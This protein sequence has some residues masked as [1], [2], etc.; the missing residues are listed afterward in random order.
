[1]GYLDA[2]LN[3]F[4]DFYDVVKTKKETTPISRPVFQ[5]GFNEMIILEAAL[6]S[7]KSRQWVEV[8]W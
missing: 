8:K 3:L 7:A 6:K 5:T 2:I 4:E 1:M